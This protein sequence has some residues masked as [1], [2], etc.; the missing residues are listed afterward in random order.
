MPFNDSCF[1]DVLWKVEDQALLEHI[2]EFGQVDFPD[3]VLD[4]GFNGLR[5]RGQDIGE[6]IVIDVIDFR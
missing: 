1:R 5:E 3:G 2:D 6:I 4:G